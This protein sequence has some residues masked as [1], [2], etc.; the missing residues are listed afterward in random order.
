MKTTS[1]IFVL[2]YNK[3]LILIYDNLPLYGDLFK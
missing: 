2:N 1:L 3:T